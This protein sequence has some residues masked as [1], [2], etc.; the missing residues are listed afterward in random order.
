MQARRMPSVISLIVGVA[1]LAV[2]AAQP[3]TPTPTPPSPAKAKLQRLRIAVA[4]L[5]WD[6][7]FTWRTAR[8]GL[9]D[10]RPALEY[11]IGI[12]RNTG[13][14][15]PELAEKW[16]MAPDGKSWTITLR[17]GVKFHDNWGEFTAKDVRHAVF[18]I[19]QPESV[20][21]TSGLWRTLMGIAGTD[22]IE[23]VTKK[24]E[25][26]WRSST[27]TRWCSGSNMRHR[28]LRRPSPPTPTW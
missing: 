13:A 1:V 11:L 17:K 18:L 16:E 7:N 9:P 2:A 3:A 21:S 19:T 20:Q 28:S 6:T 25:A 4:A 26:G 22:P 15:I 23:E 12:D 27:P 8:S 10:K 5:G 24:V 14:Y